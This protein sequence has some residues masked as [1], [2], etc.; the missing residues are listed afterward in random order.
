MACTFFFPV[1][2]ICLLIYGDFRGVCT[3]L[4]YTIDVENF[5]FQAIWVCSEIGRPPNGFL[6][7]KCFS[8]FPS[9]P[10][11]YDLAASVNIPAE[12]REIENP[13]E[14]C[15]QNRRVAHFVCNDNIGKALGTTGTAKFRS[16]PSCRGPF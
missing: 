7:S 2:P 11:D 1:T 8:G 6:Y 10:W 9:G 16:T 13:L 12:F 5:K 4:G 3:T 14:E 15:S